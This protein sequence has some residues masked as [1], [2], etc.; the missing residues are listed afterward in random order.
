MR[1]LALLLAL[2]VVSVGCD[3]KMSDETSSKDDESSSG[4]KKK[5]DKD[6]KKD[7]PTAEFEGD[8]EGAKKLLGKFLDEDTD[9]LELTKALIPHEDDYEAVFKEDADAAKKA[10]EK[11]FEKNADAKIGPNSGQTE[12][13]VFSATSEELKSG[14]GN[15]DKFPG[16][17]KKVAG[18]FKKGL[19][20]Y[21][22]K[23]TKKGESLGMAFDGLVHVNGHWAWFP[24][25][26][27]ALGDE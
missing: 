8:E 20:F 16:G 6:K 10:Y 7:N 15:A 19:T 11:L 14:D 18:K 12:L 27:K 23:F 26:W 5:K 24:K 21:A 13:K 25:P 22:W 17:Y 4:S 1:T 3:N 9:R 2:S